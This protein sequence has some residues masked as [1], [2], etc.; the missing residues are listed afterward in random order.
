MLTLPL[1][2]KCCGSILAWLGIESEY[3]WCTRHLQVCL[4]RTKLL[5][6][7]ESVVKRINFKAVCCISYLLKCLEFTINLRNILSVRH[8]G[9][10]TANLCYKF[11][12]FVYGEMEMARALCRPNPA[13]DPD[14]HIRRLPWIASHTWRGDESRVSFAD[15][16]N[17]QSPLVEFIFLPKYYVILLTTGKHYV[18]VRSQ[19]K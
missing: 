1:V 4:M 15:S 6:E 18:M 9:A 2:E 7:R 12:L 3:L 5:K 13:S 8:L 19:S 17:C 11:S 14:D 10:V 16:M